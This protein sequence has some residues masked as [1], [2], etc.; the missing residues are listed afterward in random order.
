MSNDVWVVV[1]LISLASFPCWAPIVKRAAIEI[2]KGV[3]E[4]L[5]GMGAKSVGSIARIFLGIEDD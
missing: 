3:V 5:E 1:A 4:I 2:W